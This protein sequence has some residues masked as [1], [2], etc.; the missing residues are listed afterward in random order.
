MLA[1]HHVQR[2]VVAS[3]NALYLAPSGPSHT[4]VCRSGAKNSAATLAISASVSPA[5][6]LC[7]AS[8]H[9]ADSSEVHAGDLTLD[10]FIDATTLSAAPTL[11]RTGTTVRTVL[12]TGA[13]GFLGRYL[14]LQWL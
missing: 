2:S 6:D 9:G 11:P 1:R 10:Q 5:T 3:Y 12:L 13:T 14:A 4:T 8:V 7:F